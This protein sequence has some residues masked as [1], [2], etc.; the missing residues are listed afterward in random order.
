MSY[1]PELNPAVLKGFILF[2]EI[3]FCNML[4]FKTLL[5]QTGVTKSL[6]LAIE[7]VRLAEKKWGEVNFGLFQNLN[8][9][10]GQKLVYMHQASRIYYNVVMLLI[11]YLIN[12]IELD[13]PLSQVRTRKQIHQENYLLG[14]ELHRWIT[15]PQL[16]K[17]GASFDPLVTVLYRKFI[18]DAYA[19]AERYR[20]SELHQLKDEQLLNVSLH[21]ITIRYDRIK[22]QGDMIKESI[23]GKAN[24]TNFSK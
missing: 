3:M 14:C 2:Y 13:Y 7:M 1:F 23:L 15:D 4:I 22:V 12:K 19:E 16:N 11:C 10:L 17:F 18:A 5:F 24:L 9:Q 8:P 20:V 6:E 21:T